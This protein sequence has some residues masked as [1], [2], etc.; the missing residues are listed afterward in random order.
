MGGYIF[1]LV[2]G[3]IFYFMYLF[4]AETGSGNPTLV[5][6]LNATPMWWLTWTF[7]IPGVLIAVLI[8]IILAML[9]SESYGSIDIHR[10]WR[11][12]RDGKQ[13]EPPSDLSAAAVS[14]LTGLEITGPD[15]RRN[16]DR[17]VPEGGIAS[18]A[19]RQRAQQ[20]L[21]V[22]AEKAK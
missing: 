16:G 4:G 6:A 1:G 15:A 17:D 7:L 2:L 13:P 10:N 20:S 14:L 9:V 11:S 21:K 19:G 5:S 8:A 12:A 22:V 3:A 18:L